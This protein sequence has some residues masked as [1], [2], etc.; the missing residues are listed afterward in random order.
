[1]YVDCIGSGNLGSIPRVQCN[2][3][4]KEALERDPLHSCVSQQS[5]HIGYRMEK[6]T[7]RIT[8]QGLEEID[9]PPG[10]A[11]VPSLAR[12]GHGKKL[13]AV[14]CGGG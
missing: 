11:R 9:Q 1:M 5:V 12:I 3:P 13:P 6:D 2:L 8:T 7:E 4:N 14:A 10:D